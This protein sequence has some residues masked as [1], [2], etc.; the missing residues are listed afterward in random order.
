ML[1]SDDEE[2]VSLERDVDWRDEEGSRT[3][4][5]VAPT[6]SS[7]ALVSSA[8]VGNIMPMVEGT[9]PFIADVGLT[10]SPFTYAETTDGLLGRLEQ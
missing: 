1:I 9:N 3:D 6:I 5:L 10:L 4:C 2:E 7:T 8:M